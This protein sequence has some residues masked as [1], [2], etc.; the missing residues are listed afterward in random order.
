M[1]QISIDLAA[2][3][4][5]DDWQ[6]AFS[7]SDDEGSPGRV[8]RVDRGLCGVLTADGMTRASFGGAVLDGVAADSTS[9]P[10]TGDWCS[11]RIWTDGPATIERLLP[12]RSAVVR[13]E[14][15]GTSH[16]Q[17]LAANVDYVAIVVALH[18][19]PNLARIE[20]FLSLAW[21]SGGMPLVVL[22]KAD[23]VGDA[24]ELAEDV[25]LTA[26]GVTVMLTSTVTGEGIDQLGE[27]CAGGKTM[28]LLGASG[29]G[30]SSLT[31]ALMGA[32][33]LGTRQ[34]REDGKG[35]HTTVRRELHVLPA[36]G[37][38]IDT[39]GLRG[40]GLQDSA[41][42][43]AAT[44]PDIEALISYCRFSDCSHTREPGCAVQQAIVDGT[45][46]MRRLESWQAL[47]REQAWM[48]RRSD[49][50]L[51]AEERMKWKQVS[52]HNRANRKLHP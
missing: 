1:T 14:A 25:R 32:D 12:R 36:G 38:V 10:C 23:M 33:V 13:A 42:G 40:V 24:E 44:F 39:P 20:R 51:R 6:A 18:P 46:P 15:S 16:G 31:N 49:V 43:I 50:R 48:A 27:L 28:A 11:V 9:M 7:A 17:V 30:K 3:G 37:A 19:E 35:R 4:W 22:A 34:I 52:K 26:P 29:H 41:E 2:L 45:L 8:T 47:Q 5:D 21:E